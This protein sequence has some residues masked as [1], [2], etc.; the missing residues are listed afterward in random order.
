M[1]PRQIE[2][3]RSTFAAVE[4]IA[5]IAA[6]RFYGRLFEIE[7]SLR[8]LFP[9]DMSAQYRHL[10][11]A[12]TT[13][14]RSLDRLDTIVVAIQALGRRHADYRVP[15]AAFAIGGDVLLEVLEGALGP[16]FTDEAREA[17][18]TAYGLLASVMVAAMEEVENAA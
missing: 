17:W 6:A 1:T 18:A 11:Q 15:A 9:A 13:V 10:M 4:P 8:T 14:V 12:I 7:P 3:V 2:L 5:E 16:A